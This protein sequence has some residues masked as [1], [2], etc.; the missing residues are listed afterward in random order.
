MEIGSL[1][2]ADTRSMTAEVA[3][4]AALLVAKAHKLHDRVEDDRSH[5]IKDK[6]ASDI[7]RLMQ[8]TSPAMLAVVFE[9]LLSDPVAKTPTRDGLGYL[10]QLFG[11]RGRPRVTMAID[12]LTIA[13]DPDEV[14][15]ICT[16]YMAQLDGAL[17]GP[18]GA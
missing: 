13:M 1:D 15:V 7:V 3:G 18:P 8:T 11:R 14:E 4:P 16:S 5:R 9:K 12:A 6:D 10:R 2:A 17:A